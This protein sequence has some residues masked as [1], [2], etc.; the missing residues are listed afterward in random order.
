MGEWEWHNWILDMRIAFLVISRF[1]EGYFWVRVVQVPLQEFCPE[2]LVE[3]KSLVN[4]LLDTGWL[5]GE[6][7]SDL[8]T[9]KQ[10]GHLWMSYLSDMRRVIF[11]SKIF[12]MENILGR[13]RFGDHTCFT[14]AQGSGKVQYCQLYFC[15]F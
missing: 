10:E 7:V 4:H 13:G 8:V 6:S 11:C 12:C 14:G 5:F 1:S 3:S 15:N 9:D 2:K